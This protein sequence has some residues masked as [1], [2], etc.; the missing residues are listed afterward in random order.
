MILY[1]V[2]NTQENKK[3]DVQ[4][5]E[6]FDNAFDDDLTD[7]TV[8]YSLLLVCYFILMLYRIPNLDMC[9][10]IIYALLL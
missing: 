2:L 7:M 1:R 6:S 8:Q 3:R 10:K 4:G 9:Y 5:V